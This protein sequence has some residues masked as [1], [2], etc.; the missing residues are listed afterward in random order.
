[1]HINKG[2]LRIFLAY[3]LL[4]LG[5]ATMIGFTYMQ[6][7]YYDAMIA[8]L[9]ITNAQLGILISIV[10]IGAIFTAF[11]GGI[12]VD[13]Y[14]CKK[15]LTISLGATSGLCVWFALHPTYAVALCC[16]TGLAL[17]MSGYF[18]AIFKTV[19]ILV[20]DNRQGSSFGCFGM[21]TATGFMASD[22]P[23]RDRK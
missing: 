11:P 4:G 17:T 8:T 9:G 2:S 15:V 12:L 18:P 5:Y 7:V 6:Y 22:P 13:R 16:W 21:A 14:D 23:S 3:I 20:A 19:R 10:A 1:M